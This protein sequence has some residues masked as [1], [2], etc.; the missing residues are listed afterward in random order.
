MAW[1]KVVKE[2]E[3]EGELKISLRYHGRAVGRRG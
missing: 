2:D 3:A 1:I